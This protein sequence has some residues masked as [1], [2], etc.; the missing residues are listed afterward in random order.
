MSALPALVGDRPFPHSVELERA[1]LGGAIRSGVLPAV[2]AED[3]YRPDHAALWTL[4]QAMAAEGTPIESVT[5]LERIARGRRPDRYGGIP[6]VVELPDAVPATANLAWYAG[7]VVELARQRRD[8]AA[9][10]EMVD[11]LFDAPTH[12]LSDEHRM[13][14]LEQVVVGV[15]QPLSRSEVARTVNAALDATGRGKR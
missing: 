1:L 2:A 10:L 13:A 3:F 8:I 11:A 5:V 7:R 14:L 12:G 6:N 4:M 15:G 9:L